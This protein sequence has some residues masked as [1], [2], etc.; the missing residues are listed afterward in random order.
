[1]TYTSV[2]KTPYFPPL[3]SL[4][5]KLREFPSP[6][7]QKM[8]QLR[9][10]LLRNLGDIS[11]VALENVLRFLKGVKWINCREIHDLHFCSSREIPFLQGHIMKWLVNHILRSH[12][13][14]SEIPLEDMQGLRK[15]LK[16]LNN[17]AI[18]AMDP[19]KGTPSGGAI[20]C[21]TFHY[22]T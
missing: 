14:I 1:M 7:G 10:N 22:L 15:G 4:W 5:E 13:A 12:R 16:W 19:Y 20:Y 8:K 3:S 21:I 17:K 6:Q 9:N 2:W 18:F 11:E